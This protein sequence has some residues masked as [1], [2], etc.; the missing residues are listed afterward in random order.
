MSR[1]PEKRFCDFCGE[2]EDTKSFQGKI[3]QY[4]AYKRSIWI[5]DWGE[6]RPDQKHEWPEFDICW[7]CA[8]KMASEKVAAK[9]VMIF[10]H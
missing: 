1:I 5:E 7:G 3:A 2:P 4:Q 10:P 8:Q 6:H 9:P